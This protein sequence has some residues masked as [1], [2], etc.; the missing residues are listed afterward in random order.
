[1]VKQVHTLLE[2][3]AAIGVCGG[4]LSCTVIYFNAVVV[5]QYS[6]LFFFF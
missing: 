1:M 6:V 4:G 2:E 5:L 3:A